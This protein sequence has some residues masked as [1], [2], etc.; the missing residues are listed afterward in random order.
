MSSFLPMLYFFF[1]RPDYLYPVRAHAAISCVLLV[2][3]CGKS[4]IKYVFESSFS[5]SCP[6][7]YFDF[8]EFA[9]QFVSE[10]CSLASRVI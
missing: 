4:S 7:K 6:S 5:F 3:F 8:V 2:D 10:I 9:R 1:V